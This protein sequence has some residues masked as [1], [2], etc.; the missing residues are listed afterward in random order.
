[1]R[2]LRSSTARIQR[3]KSDAECWKA[4]LDEHLRAGNVPSTLEWR[5]ILAE[6]TEVPLDQI[7]KKGSGSV[8]Y[9]KALHYLK[10]GK[11][12][13]RLTKKKAHS[14]RTR[15]QPTSSIPRALPKTRL[16]PDTANDP[17]K[18]SVETQTDSNV[19]NRYSMGACFSGNCGWIKAIDTHQKQ[20]K[21]A[22]E[23]QEELESKLTQSQGENQ[24]LKQQIDALRID[25]DN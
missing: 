18:F 14:S 17:Q 9:I 20:L 25:R 11:K 19:R 4:R 7:T 23:K 21:Q 15:G 13:Y 12:K 22:K 24:R 8:H 2:I 1:M 16:A 10:R 3:T 6:V 5:Q